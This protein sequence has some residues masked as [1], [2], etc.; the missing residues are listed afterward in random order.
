MAVT[1]NWKDNKTNRFKKRF[2]SLGQTDVTFYQYIFS[3]YFSNPN[4]NPLLTHLAQISDTPC[5]YI[6]LCSSLSLSLHFLF[7]PCLHL[8]P[9]DLSSISLPLPA[10]EAGELS[11]YLC[12]GIIGIH[13]CAWDRA[14]PEQGPGPRHDKQGVSKPPRDP[15][16]CRRATGILTYA[17]L[18]F[19]YIKQP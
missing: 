11:H 9:P 18:I 19:L 10:V 5:F 13:V 16:I 17:R 12:I 2:S 15:L 6:P 7:P 3:L 14:H 4:T 8:S 1:R